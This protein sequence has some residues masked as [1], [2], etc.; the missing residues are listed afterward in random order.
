[1]KSLVTKFLV[2]AS[3]VIVLS[4]ANATPVTYD[5]TASGF[6]P[7][8]GNAAPNSTVSGSFT[9]DGS[10]VTGINLQLGSHTF[11]VSEV[12]LAN[13]GSDFIGG[14]L[15]NEGCINS[16]TDDFW[17]SGN[18]SDTPS[19]IEFVYA[20]AGVSGIW[21]TDTGTLTVRQET[22]VPEPESLALFGVA[23]AGLALTRRKT[24]QA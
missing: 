7:S 2:A 22:S 21:S 11:S 15:C 14:K 3:C 6:A 10:S 4:A 12:G 16:T 9:L 1:M 24:K 19:F 8:N 5:F 17:L 13:Y 23:L 18:F 20:V